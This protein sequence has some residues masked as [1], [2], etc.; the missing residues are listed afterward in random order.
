[1]SNDKVAKAFAAGLFKNKTLKLLNLE[2]NYITGAGIVELLEAI[3]ANQAVSEFRVANQR[4]QI[5]GVKIETEIAEL[6][7]GNASLLRF[8]IFLEARNARVVVT[9]CLK[10]NNDNLR[11]GRVGE[12]IIRPTSEVRSPL[13]D[14]GKAE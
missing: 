5:L 10:R 14:K 4:P 9:D 7:R 12:E 1:M 2:S 13:V 6:I 8:G 3:N 11:R